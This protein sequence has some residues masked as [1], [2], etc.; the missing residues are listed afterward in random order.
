MQLDMNLY[1]TT[2]SYRCEGCRVSPTFGASLPFHR[3]A[4]LSIAVVVVHSK[5]TNKTHQ[6]MSNLVKRLSKAPADMPKTPKSDPYAE[7]IQGK[8]TQADSSRVCVW[9]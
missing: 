3:I 5:Q 6:G 8:A 1:T 2:T 4:S 7:S 9:V